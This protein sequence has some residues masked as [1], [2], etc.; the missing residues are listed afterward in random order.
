MINSY[1]GPLLDVE[2]WG[3]LRLLLTSALTPLVLATMVRVGNRARSERDFVFADSVSVSDAIQ[4][5]ETLQLD[6]ILKNYELYMQ[7]QDSRDDLRK[8][9]GTLTSLKSARSFEDATKWPGE[10]WA[11]AYELIRVHLFSFLLLQIA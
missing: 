10:V 5:L 2:S 4:P 3:Q 1:R 9:V 6:V 7:F 11:P 8:L